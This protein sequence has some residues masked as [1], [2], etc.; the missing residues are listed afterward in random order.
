MKKFF[1]T[2]WNSMA[3]KD[4][5]DALVLNSI[6]TLLFSFATFIFGLTLTFFID[7]IFKRF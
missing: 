2:V 5:A 1:S 6:A 7:F 4:N 3:D